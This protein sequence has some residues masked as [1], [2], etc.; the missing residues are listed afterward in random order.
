MQ[1][2]AGPLAVVALGVS[3]GGLAVAIWAAA[4]A[5]RQAQEAQRANAVQTFVLVSEA[6]GEFQKRKNGSS[7]LVLG[8]DAVDGPEIGLWRNASYLAHWDALADAVNLVGFVC[9]R[10]LI[11]EDWALEAWGPLLARYRDFVR[12]ALVWEGGEPPSHFASIRSLLDESV[13]RWS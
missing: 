3:L 10:G 2:A 9:A 6:F 5:R 8:Q 11:P 4:C 13:R 7:R 12:D 1:E